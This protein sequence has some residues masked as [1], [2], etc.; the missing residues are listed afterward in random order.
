MN[1]WEPR[2]KIRIYPQI[3]NKT[4]EN[5]D[6]KHWKNNNVIPPQSLPKEQIVKEDSILKNLNKITEFS[7]RKNQEVVIRPGMY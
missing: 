1:Q 6:L 7:L 3:S 4:E 5:K 2:K